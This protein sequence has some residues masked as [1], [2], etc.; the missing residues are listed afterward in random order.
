MHRSENE[1]RKER[2]GNLGRTCALASARERHC[3]SARGSVTTKVEWAAV[4]SRGQGGVKREGG[5][6]VDDNDPLMMENGVKVRWGY[7]FCVFFVLW[8][9]ACFGG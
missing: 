9:F 3:H 8:L 1:V 7:F 4:P 2:N 5:G 6:K